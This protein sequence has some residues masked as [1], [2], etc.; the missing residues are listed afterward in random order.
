MSGHTL[1][2]RC[3]LGL[4]SVLLGLG[5]VAPCMTIQPNFGAYSSWVQWIKPDLAA[6][7]TYSIFG[8]IWG[9]TCNES[10]GLGLLLLSF[11]VVF[12]AVKLTMLWRGLV[13]I[14]RGQPT[15]VA[16]W[17]T[18]HAGKFS[19]LDVMVIALLVIAIKGLPGG[20]TIVVGWGLFAFA[21]S[22]ILSMLASVLVRRQETG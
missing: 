14:E 15:G 21:G 20:T 6:P 7:T 3:L 4:A 22:V 11:S 16:L 17:V 10:T 18:H 12:P 1:L 19:M 9:L 8:G 5:L 13:Q 2:I